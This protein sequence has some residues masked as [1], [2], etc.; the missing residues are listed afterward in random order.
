MLGQRVGGGE[1][2]ALVTVFPP[3]EIRRS[4]MVTADLHDHTPTVLIPH[5]MP[6]NHQLIAHISAHHNRLLP[7]LSRSS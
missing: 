3:D 7:A 5:V 2:H 1:E 4:A 6:P